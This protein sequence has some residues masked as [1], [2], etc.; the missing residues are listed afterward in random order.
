MFVYLFSFQ[1]KKTSP[2]QFKFEIGSYK[3]QLDGERLRE[4]SSLAGRTHGEPTARAGADSPRLG[5]AAEPV[6]E[7]EPPYGVAR[8][9]RGGARSRCFPF[10]TQSGSA[11]APAASLPTPRRFQAAA[12]SALPPPSER[13]LTA[14]SRSPELLR[15]RRSAVGG[16]RAPSA[17]PAAEL[18]RRSPRGSA[19]AARL[20]AAGPGGVP[21]R[22]R[23]C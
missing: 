15:G 23:S 13:R 11:A 1:R 8:S 22:R 21:A 5:G 6:A 19:P 10:R 7:R 17:G 4:G 9:G 3:E 18:H 14:R 20:P 12:G 2:R 16:R